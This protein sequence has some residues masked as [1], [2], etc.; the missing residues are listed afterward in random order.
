MFAVGNCGN[1]NNDARASA[2]ADI[3]T[4]S[5]TATPN[6]SSILNEFSAELNTDTSNGLL[7]NISSQVVVEK[8]N[9]HLP[10]TDSV[11]EANVCQEPPIETSY[12]S[13]TTI[14]KTSSGK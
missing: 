14:A 10:S 8:K 3:N 12:Q 7:K 6:K 1:I 5:T 2:G 9:N 4:D 11:E 13:K